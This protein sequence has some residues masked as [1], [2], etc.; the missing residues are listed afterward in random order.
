MH[1]FIIPARSGSKGFPGKNVHMYK[2]LPLALHS[3]NYALEYSNPGDKIVISSDSSHYLD[4]FHDYGV[5]QSS[6]SLRPSCLAE[7]S[8]T[9]YP[10]VLYEWAKLEEKSDSIF[11]LIFLLRPTSPHRPPNLISSAIEIFNNDPSVTSVRAVRLCKEHPYRVWSL[12]E[13]QMTPLISHTREPG[14]IPRQ[15]LPHNYYFQSG[16]L[17]VTRRETLASGSICGNRVSPLLIDKAYPDVDH[18]SDL[19]VQ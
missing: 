2:G 13:D 7:D 14:N 3:Y 19:P 12:D 17:E 8:V 4:I 10:V 5:P 15:H 11:P 6:L 1:L 9:D 18:K 16:E